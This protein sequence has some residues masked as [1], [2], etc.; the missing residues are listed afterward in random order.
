MPIA[1]NDAADDPLLFDAQ[2]SFLGGMVSNTRVNLLTPDQ[3]ALLQDVDVEQNGRLR[4]RRG[5]R[6]IGSLRTLSGGAMVQGLHWFD[7]VQMGCLVAAAGGSLYGLDA[8]GSW[9]LIHAGALGSAALPAYIAQVNDRLFAAA[10]QFE[11]DGERRAVAAAG[12]ER[13][14]VAVGE[15][16]G[17]VG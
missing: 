12:D 9:H 10:G 17:A 6:D 3:A 2:S 16:T 14:G 5:F 1:Y 8:S 15:D 13:A 4:T 7:N 11:D